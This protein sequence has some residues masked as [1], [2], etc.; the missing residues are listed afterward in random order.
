MFHTARMSI[1]EHREPGIIIR[2]RH[3]NATLTSEGATP[4]MF[5][6][7]GQLP[8]TYYSHSQWLSVM[9]TWLSIAAWWSFRDI[10]DRVDPFCL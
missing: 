8:G 1:L 3:M 10:R 4:F 7:G 5:S 6:T 9:G 2:W